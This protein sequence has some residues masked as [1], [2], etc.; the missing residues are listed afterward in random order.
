MKQQLPRLQGLL[1]KVYNAHHQNHGQ[2]LTDLRQILEML[3]DDIEMH[4]AKEERILFPYIRQIE[5]Y[6]NEK[7][8]MPEMHCGTVQNPIGQMEYEHQQVAEALSRI[9]EITSNFHLPDDACN[10]FRALYDS[11]KDLEADLHEH[12]HL[13]NNVLFPRAVELESSVPKLQ[14]R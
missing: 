13:E 14:E 11:L 3:Q 5:T 4:L 1:A 8:P 2:M 10:T 6:A 7:R 12:I 9:K